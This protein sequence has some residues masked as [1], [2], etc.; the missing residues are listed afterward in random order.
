MQP[1]TRTR[2][3]SFPLNEGKW[4]Q[5]NNDGEVTILDDATS[6]STMDYWRMTDTVG[7]PERANPLVATKQHS[8]GGMCNGSAKIGL[9]EITMVNHR[10]DSLA[11]LDKIPSKAPPY[12]WGTFDL[13][14]ILART[15]PMTPKVN[16]PLFLTEL[17]DV[18]RMIRHA[19]DTLHGISRFSEMNPLQQAASSN[20][21][22]KFGWDPLI[23]DIRKIS[24]I[25]D[26][27][28]KRQKFLMK[29]DEVLGAVSK[30]YLGSESYVNENDYDGPYP[31]GN[32]MITFAQP[33]T[34]KKTTEIKR[35]CSVRWRLR[36][37]Q[38][39][40]MSEPPVTPFQAVTGLHTSNIPLTIWKALPWTWLSDWFVDLSSSIQAAQNLLYFEPTDICW[41]ESRTTTT[42]ISAATIKYNTNGGGVYGTCSRLNYVK[43]EKY[44]QVLTG[45]ESLVQAKL[46]MMD[47]FKL[48]VLGSLATLRLLGR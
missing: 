38:P 30:A 18:P 7:F 32:W 1:G 35:W 26:Y 42:E 39:L 31:F 11:R 17:R 3:K 47:S 40:Y 33:R 14:T 28:K 21:A 48:S 34:F 36:D 4:I 5:V 45:D 6:V 13:A 24:N 27:T 46:P 19:G 20:L 9:D 23:S 44:R 2:T 16:V 41:M 37:F 22:Y 12:D 29:T 43:T 25:M 8:T 10:I 15:G